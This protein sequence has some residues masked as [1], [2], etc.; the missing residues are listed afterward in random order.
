[1]M[2]YLGA[3]LGPAALIPLAVGCSNRPAQA[4][5]GVPSAPGNE[6]GTPSGQ[7][8]QGMGTEISPQ[9][10]T[11]QLGNERF[12]QQGMGSGIGQQGTQ[13]YG[14]GQVGQGQQNQPGQQG[15]G[16]GVGSA[17]Q[18]GEPG[19]VQ[20]TSEKAACDAL[21]NSAKLHVEDVQNG[22]AIVASPKGGTSL[23]TVREDARRLEAAIRTGGEGGQRGRAESC[24]IAELGR[25][26]SVSVQVTEAANS[27]RI[28]MTTSNN[29][30]VKDL[31]RIA[32]D[33]VA[34][35]SKGAGGQQPKQQKK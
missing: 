30:E 25:L 8:Q 2:K 18:G 21:V 19:Q 34:T 20:A 12:G 26:P 23:S 28:Q 5:T 29:A 4:P 35:M 1:M 15:F 7:Q 14:Q 27:V 31:R 13:E 9:G 16:A 11:G 3:A 24:G 22:I 17:E 10:P 33:E 6:P 32:R